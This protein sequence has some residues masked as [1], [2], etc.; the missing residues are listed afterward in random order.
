MVI[1]DKS[2]FFV[3]ESVQLKSVL[4]KFYGAL[5]K[6]LSGTLL[7]RFRKNGVP[8]HELTLKVGDV[9]LVTRAIHGL[10]LANNSRICI[11][12]IHIASSI[13]P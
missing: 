3:S 6:M 12:A 9:C 10:G 2:W 5:K 4:S 1:I 7:N 8:N 13:V 11:I